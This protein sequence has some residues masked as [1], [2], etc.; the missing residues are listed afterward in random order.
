MELYKIRGGDGIEYGPANIEQVLEL[1]KQGRVKATTMVFV[2]SANRWHL[3]ASVTEVRAML[4]Q[5]SPK[6]DSTLDRIRAQGTANPRDSA[7]ANMAVGRISTVRMK[8]N[9]FWKKLFSKS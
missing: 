1:V 3:A 6:P 5:F 4:R 2:Q 9:P 7:Y 8:R